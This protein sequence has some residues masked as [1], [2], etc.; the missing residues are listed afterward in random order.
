MQSTC[1]KLEWTTHREKFHPPPS[2]C[3]P[4]PFFFTPYPLGLNYWNNI[5]FLYR[6]LICRLHMK[7]LRWSDGPEI[8]SR[9]RT[10]QGLPIPQLPT[11]R[12]APSIG[13]VATQVKG[14]QVI[15]LVYCQTRILREYV[16]LN[17]W[18]PTLV[19]LPLT[20]K[21]TKSYFILKLFTSFKTPNSLR[22]NSNSW[23]MWGTR[24]SPIYFSSDPKHGDLNHANPLL[25]I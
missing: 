3:H 14:T 18:A 12:C 22:A 6:P 19:A 2:E 9:C 16:C 7:G 17:R 23:K 24:F 15:R 25:F 21:Q 10:H 13:P 1:H 4:I 5:Q 8:L 20:C 11:P